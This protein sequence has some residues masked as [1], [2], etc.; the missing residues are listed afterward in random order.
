MNENESYLILDEQEEKLKIFTKK[1]K[2]LQILHEKSSTWVLEKILTTYFA[3]GIMPRLNDYQ[4]IYIEKGKDITAHGGRMVMKGK[5]PWKDGTHGMENHLQNVEDAL[6][7]EFVAKNIIESA[8]TLVTTTINALF[9]SGSQTQ[10]N[11]YKQAIPQSNFIYMMLKIAVKLIGNDLYNK[12]VI[13]TNSTLKYMTEM[14]EK[15]NKRIIELFQ[16]SIKNTGEINEAVSVYYEIL[17]K[18]FDDFIKS[19]H[20]FSIKEALK[21]GEENHIIATVGE[22]NVISYIEFLIVNIQKRLMHSPLFNEDLITIK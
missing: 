8:A 5:K 15:D 4:T 9:Y 11:R 19:N 10:I 6:G 14:I 18:Y 2:A 12:E 20:L 1:V 13:P 16:E 7:L 3:R 22:D 17:D 21:I